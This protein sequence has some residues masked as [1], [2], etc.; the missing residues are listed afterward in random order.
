MSYIYIYIHIYWFIY[1]HN[2]SYLCIY[3]HISIFIYVYLY[4]W[5]R[6]EDLEVTEDLLGDALEGGVPRMLLQRLRDSRRRV[7]L[8]YLRVGRESERT[9][10]PM[11]TKNVHLVPYADRKRPMLTRAGSSPHAAPALPRQSSTR[12]SLVPTPPP[13]SLRGGA[14]RLFQLH[15]FIPKVTGFRWVPVQIKGVNKTIW[16][17][18]EGWRE[19]P[20]CCSSVSETV[21]D[22]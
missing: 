20:A 19:F 13:P 18:S 5:Q 1:I 8:L 21:F 9:W 16:S 11:L 2:F 3:I 7:D 15:W 22:A 12:R 17:R 14:N 10:R 6:G 4:I